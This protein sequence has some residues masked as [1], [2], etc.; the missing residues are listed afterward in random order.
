MCS[1]CKAIEV[2]TEWKPI[3][4]AVEELSLLTQESCPAIKQALCESCRKEYMQD[5][6]AEDV[7]LA[8]DIQDVL[9]FIK[10]LFGD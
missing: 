10:R 4:K 2:G 6:I 3:K 1:W 7:K 5:Y 8:S 9:P